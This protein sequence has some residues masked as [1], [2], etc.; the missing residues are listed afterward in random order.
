[1]NNKAVV[2]GLSDEAQLFNLKNDAGEN[3]DLHALYSDIQKK[4]GQTLNGILE[5]S[6]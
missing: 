6:Q 3:K 2:K 1:M 4:M 5:E